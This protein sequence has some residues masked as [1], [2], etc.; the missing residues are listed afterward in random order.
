MINKKYYYKLENRSDKEI[1][2]KD[3]IFEFEKVGDET[4]EKYKLKK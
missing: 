1:L 2:R 4:N 3:A